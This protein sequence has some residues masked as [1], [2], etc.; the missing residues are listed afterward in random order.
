M[1]QTRQMRRKYVATVLAVFV[2]AC[3]AIEA[4]ALGLFSV[5]ANSFSTLFLVSAFSLL[6]YTVVSATI[7]FKMLDRSPMSV[8]RY[9]MVHTM[10]RFAFGGIVLFACHC[11]APEN[12]KS[13]L[14]A[15]GILFLTMLVSES[16][17]YIQ[18]ERYLNENKSHV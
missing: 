2:A 5:S 18:I 6:F 17:I 13:A 16:V 12:S 4:T 11:F 10:S 1:E 14:I 9:Y 15:F 3:V 8:A 7:Y